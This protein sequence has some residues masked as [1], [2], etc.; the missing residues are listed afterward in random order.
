M[1]GALQETSASISASDLALIADINASDKQPV[2]FVHGHWLLRGSWDRWANVFEDAGRAVLA[3]G[4]PDEPETVELAKAD[5]E[6][7]ATMTVDRLEQHLLAIVGA[8]RR[9]PAIIGHGLGGLLAQTLAGR[10]LSS[11][12][13]AIDPA[14]FQRVL[15]PP[16]SSLKAAWSV[17]GNPANA[18]RAVPM[19]YKQFRSG[20][21][22]AVNEDEAQALFE[23]FIVPASGGPMFRSAI[24]KLNP[25]PGE[26]VDI[27]NPLRGPLLIIS[28]E[29]DN[30]VPR[31]IAH[32]SF[33]LQQDNPG[34]T[35]FVEMPSRGHS[36]VIDSGW[37]EE[38]GIALEFVKQFA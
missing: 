16:I 7:L 9:K 37:S 1:P 3:P 14:P 8:L 17:L 20:F 29:N 19:T 26:R 18:V 24:A 11:A 31:S 23:T 13:V 28:G 4:W 15:S 6:A 22:N 12:T 21:A 34:M 35:E 33:K 25:W 36:L 5:P 2:V 27:K 10:G 30:L 32:A 38:D